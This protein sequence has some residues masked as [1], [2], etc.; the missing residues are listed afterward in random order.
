MGEILTY[1]GKTLETADG[2]TI[3]VARQYVVECS[4]CGPIYTHQDGYTVPETRSDALKAQRE[5]H[6]FHVR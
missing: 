4:D 5:H 1:L 3:D 2:Y 6:A